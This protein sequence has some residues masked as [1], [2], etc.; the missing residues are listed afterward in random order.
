[1]SVVG[2]GVAGADVDQ[3][4]SGVVREPVPGRAAAAV[5]PVIVRR[6]SFRGGL[7]IRLILRAQFWIARHGIEPPLEGAGLEI[8]GGDEAARSL[9]IR[10]AVAD[11][12]HVAGQYRRAGDR[13]VKVRGPA[14][15]Q[16]VGS[17][18]SFAGAG[19]DGMQVAVDAGD[20]HPALPNHQT[21]I[22]DIAAGVAAPLTVDLRI[23]GPQ[24]LAARG[25]ERVDPAP[26]AG[27][28]HH[29]VDHHGRALQTA[30]SSQ[31]VVPG[32]A[33]ASGVAVVDGIQRRVIR[34]FRVASRR[35]PLIRL[36][37]CIRETRR[38]DRGRWS[39]R[40]LRRTRALRRRHFGEDGEQ[41]KPTPHRSAHQS[42]TMKRLPP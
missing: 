16:G 28:V 15:G 37:S 32:E 11:G 38:I 10:A 41:E 25:I 26:I 33:Q 29:A 17:P 1:M 34:A 3:M 5:A 14:G 2:G 18:D 12:D 7:Q 42:L 30:A 24:L 21:A 6:P 20:V 9:E 36:A 40:C 27:R 4:Q 22:D 35:E 8:Q 31:V 13:I 23:V 19:I 39:C